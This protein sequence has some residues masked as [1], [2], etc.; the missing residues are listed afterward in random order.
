MDRLEASFHLDILGFWVELKLETFSVTVSTHKLPLAQ[1]QT[2]LWLEV[3]NLGGWTCWGNKHS[4]NTPIDI[5]SY[6]FAL[7]HRIHF[8]A[9]GKDLFEK[10][11]ASLDLISPTCPSVGVGVH[12]SVCSS[13]PCTHAIDQVRGKSEEG[14]TSGVAL[15]GVGWGEECPDAAQR[16]SPSELCQWNSVEG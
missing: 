2:E 9:V 6:L 1:P 13:G 4:I 10:S 7:S 5:Q 15:V 8:L 16:G 11:S 14:V 12:S 3:I